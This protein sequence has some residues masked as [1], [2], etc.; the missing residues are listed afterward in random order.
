DAARKFPAEESER[1][2]KAAKPGYQQLVD[3]YKRY[4][5]YDLPIIMEERKKLTIIPPTMTVDGEL[6][7]YNKKREIRIFYMGFGNTDGDLWIYLPKEK[8]LCSGDAV[9]HPIPYGY[10]FNQTELLK[11]LKKAVQMDFEILIP[12]HGDVQYDKRFIN[13]YIEFLDYTLTEVDKRYK[14]GITAEELIKAID[15]GDFERRFAGTDP[16]SLYYFHGYTFEP[17]VNR[18]L[19]QLEKE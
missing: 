14:K 17:T 9:V 11:T 3:H 13:L 19:A 5:D 8:I 18:Y 7:F 4:A 16:V 15:V 6:I 12:G 2:R 10:S 1:I